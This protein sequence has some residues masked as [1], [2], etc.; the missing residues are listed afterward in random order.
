MTMT[1]SKRRA[2]SIGNDLPHMPEA[3]LKSILLP[4]GGGGSISTRYAAHASPAQAASAGLPPSPAD[5][6]A[7][8]K[9]VLGDYEDVDADQ[10]AD[11]QD[12]SVLLTREARRLQRMEPEKLRR[13]RRI[14]AGTA[15]LVL[16]ALTAYCLA[17]YTL[18]WLHLSPSGSLKSPSTTMAMSV[19]PLMQ[20]MALLCI[21]LT[22]YTLLLLVTSAV[23]LRFSRKRSCATP[24]IFLAVLLGGV[25]MVALALTN[26]GLIAAWHGY[27][28]TTGKDSIRAAT[29][30]VAR[31]C[32]GQWEFDFIWNAAEASPMNNAAG[33]QVCEASDRTF[34]IFVAVACVRASLF[35]FFTVLFLH[36]LRRY[37]QSLGLGLSKLV[38]DHEHTHYVGGTERKLGSDSGVDQRLGTVNE[39]AEMHAYLARRENTL[40][41][42]GPQVSGD[43]HDDTLR[44][45][46]VEKADPYVTLCNMGQSS[47]RDAP[48]SDMG[49]LAPRLSRFGWQRGEPS[50][51]DHEYHS[52][53]LHVEA[54]AGDAA[55]HPGREASA[56]GWGAALYR[57]LWGGPDQTQSPQTG[58]RRLLVHSEAVE[59]D[60][61]DGEEGR[62]RLPVLDHDHWYSNLDGNHSPPSVQHDK[63]ASRLGVSGWFGG[64][65]DV[66]EEEEAPQPWRPRRPSEQS[67]HAADASLT[68]H[69]RTPSQERRRIEAR[70]AASKAARARTGHSE[71]SVHSAGL[72]SPQLSP[73]LGDDL[74]SMPPLMD[75][76]APPD[77]SRTRTTTQTQTRTPT[78][79]PPQPVSDA[80]AHPRQPPS[81]VRSLGRMVQK[82]PSIK[83]GDGDGSS[84]REAS[85]S[86]ARRGGSA[87]SIANRMSRDSF[88]DTVQESVPA[89]ATA[90][91]TETAPGA[92]SHLR[93]LAP[94]REDTQPRC[95]CG[96]ATKGDF[97]QYQEAPSVVR[98]DG[99]LREEERHLP[100]A[101]HW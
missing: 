87:V 100:G 9:T 64:G 79:R 47:Q 41:S 77:V 51:H 52:L 36:L 54:T 57:R 18:A 95:T 11:A 97:D 8:N 82:L 30:D 23:Y 40:R 7:T 85:E 99:G 74:P 48:S 75:P 76:P 65:G 29:R 86:S 44:G 17:R 83:S 60:D 20:T 59:P 14:L 19:D 2:P 13:R 21:V 45:R 35:A 69:Q 94:V 24:V 46:D 58:E 90:D 27:Y 3:P 43:F 5:S 49:S 4:S 55:G 63:G 33:L 62:R 56:E 72:E 28:S 22:A 88:Y 38:T 31:R 1:T 66:S 71:A 84:S 67:S 80:A 92:S 91:A 32:R 68:A 81:Y 50:T 53:P 6:P 10:A 39:S 70:H 12:D 89:A 15:C 37:N 16:M 98:G 96:Q 101:W 93:S 42:G 34:Y 26:L 61:E 25:I 78:R 73:K